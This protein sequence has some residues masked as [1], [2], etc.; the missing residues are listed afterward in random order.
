MRREQA[1]AGRA[2]RRLDRGAGA[3][4]LP[5]QDR[6][7][8]PERRGGA[9]DR[10]GLLGG[11]GAQAVVDRGD[12]EPVAPARGGGPHQGGGI[13]AA[14]D[15]QQQV[16]VPGE[17]RGEGVGEGVLEGATDPFGGIVARPA[18]AAQRARFCSRTTPWRTPEPA[19]GNLR[20]SSASV[21]QA[22]SRAPRAFSETPSFSIASGAW[23]ERA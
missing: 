1:V 14:G 21:A 15:G 20:S 3:G 18:H 6:V 12:E 13:G 2:R 16:R 17:P 22:C 7:R 5:A 4:A 11:F 10:P 23:G 8:E 9:G 19:A